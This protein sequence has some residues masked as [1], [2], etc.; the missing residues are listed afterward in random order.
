MIHDS[1]L[2]FISQ[3]EQVVAPVAV[4]VAVWVL[5]G[6]LGKRFLGADDDFWPAIRG[7]VLPAVDR[8]AR[9]TGLYAEGHSKPYEYAGQVATGTL[10]AFEED[11][12]AMGYT[13]NPLAAY[14]SYTPKGWQSDGSWAKRYGYIRG[15]G[16]LLRNCSAAQAVPGPALLGRFLQGL[17]DILALRQ[18]HVTVY[19]QESRFTDRDTVHCFVHDE[20]NSLNPLT[21]WRHYRGKGFHADRGVSRFQADL[22]EY[23]AEH[24]LKYL[25]DVEAPGAAHSGAE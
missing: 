21:A 2:R 8:I 12:E 19:Y 18:V 14:K 22:K 10:D 6:V 11:L 5:Y 1:I 3:N 15:T 24:D 25:F 7:R 16:D 17:G 23:A 9:G 4:F 13:R 20:A